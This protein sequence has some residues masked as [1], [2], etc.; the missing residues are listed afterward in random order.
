MNRIHQIVS[1]LSI[2]QMIELYNFKGYPISDK[3][4]MPNVF[5][6]RS[7]NT[8]PNKFDDAIGIFRLTRDGES[9]EMNVWDSTTDPGLYWLQRPENSMG[10]A[11]LVP[12]S[13][14]AYKLG[15]HKNKYPALVQRAGEVSVYRDGDRDVELDNENSSGGIDTGYFGI[16]IHRANEKGTSINVDKWSA[17]CQVIADYRDFDTLMGYVDAAVSLY[18]KETI[19]RYSLFVE[20]DVDLIT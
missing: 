10:T 4:L 17:G 11:I 5:G 19:F 7:S 14:R 20:A 1:E 9:Y 3:P 15:L 13:Y 6:F 16:N 8:K 12:G 2:D 18:G